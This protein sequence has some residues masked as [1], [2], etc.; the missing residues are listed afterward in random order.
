LLLSLQADLDGERL[1]EDLKSNVQS[2]QA[3]DAIVR[4]RTSQGKYGVVFFNT[5]YI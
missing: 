5:T 3:F 4:V 2:Q 1:M